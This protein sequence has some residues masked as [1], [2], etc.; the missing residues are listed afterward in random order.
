MEKILINV[1]LLKQRVT[2][3]FTGGGKSFEWIPKKYKGRELHWRQCVGSE[4][5]VLKSVSA[6]L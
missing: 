6:V 5:G 3:F 2:V 1:L 4:S